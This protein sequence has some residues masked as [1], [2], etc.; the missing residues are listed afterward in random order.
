MVLTPEWFPAFGGRRGIG[1][2]RRAAHTLE[3]WPCPTGFLRGPIP[4]R[5]MGLSCEGGRTVPSVATSSL[6]ERSLFVVFLAPPCRRPSPRSQGCGCR[7]GPGGVAA[8]HPPFASDTS[9]TTAAAAVAQCAP[10]AAAKR[11][12]A[13]VARPEGPVRRPNAQGLGLDCTHQPP[14]HRQQWIC[15]LLRRKRCKLRGRRPYG[16]HPGPS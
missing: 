10:T 16:A 7:V 14:S 9:F 11:R 5:G 15:R 4:R 8:P 3:A 2:A 6:V 12:T 13:G 1:T